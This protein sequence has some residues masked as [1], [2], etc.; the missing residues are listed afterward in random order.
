MIRS[1]YSFIIVFALFTACS[2]GDDDSVIDNDN[3]I[4]EP[5]DDNNSPGD[6]DA[7]FS[8]VAHRGAWKEFDL[9][10]NSVAALKKAAEIG[11][12]ISECDIQLTADEE[13]VVFHDET[14]QGKY[15]KDMTYEELQT[16]KLS[17][18]EEIPL[19]SDFIDVALQQDIQL[20][21]DVKSLSDAAG[22]NERSILAGEMAAEIV[23]TQGAEKKVSFI[24]G[25]KEVLDKCIAAA[26]GDW[27]C[28]YM[29]TDYTA[30]QFEQNGYSWANFSYEK[31]YQ[32]TAV[33]QTYLDK[34]IKVSV[35]TVDDNE[36]MDWFAD[37]DGIYAI[38]TNFPLKLK[39][40]K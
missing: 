20:W 1:V 6:D 37:R 22:G 34:N 40:K 3:P 33:L 27:D 26:R 2:G 36:T 24:V 14:I 8:V 31:F 23:R 7:T 25:R 30:E 15:L 39:A 17:N 21:L 38:S 28:A 35:Y 19:L 32:N 16:H 5:G 12:D 10:E 11:S 29:N 4:E 18:G 13:V 9:P